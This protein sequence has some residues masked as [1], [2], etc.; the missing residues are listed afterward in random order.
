MLIT[1][2][3]FK[4]LA[5]I[6]IQKIKNNNKK[7]K[8]YHKNY[9]E[10]FIE[11]TKN[12]DFKDILINEKNFDNIFYKFCEY[13][14]DNKRID[15][16]N[17]EKLLIAEKS[18]YCCAMPHCRVYTKKHDTKHIKKSSGFGEAA[19]I[20]S[21]SIKNKVR[22][23]IGIDEN[24]IASEKNGV[25]LCSNCHSY[26]DYSALEFMYDVDLIFAYKNNIEEEVSSY[27]I[28]KNK[29]YN[30]LN[31]S[32]KK[33]LQEKIYLGKRHSGDFNECDSDTAKFIA[34]NNGI[35]RININFNKEDFFKYQNLE[36]LALNINN[37]NFHNV[38][39]L[40]KSIY[41]PKVYIQSYEHR[42]FLLQFKD[43]K[44]KYLNLNIKHCQLIKKNNQSIS[45]GFLFD[46]S[47]N[48]HNFFIFK[49]IFDFIKEQVSI[50]I[51][52]DIENI[53]ESN[54]KIQDFENFQYILNFIEAL[55]NDQV[56][57]KV[58]I[59][60]N[61]GYLTINDYQTLI[62]DL[63]YFKKMVTFLSIVQQISINEDINIDI[64]KDL[65]DKNVFFI[66][67]L[68]F[69]EYVIF[70]EDIPETFFIRGLKIIDKINESQIDFSE[71]LINFNINLICNNFEICIIFNNFRL[72]LFEDSNHQLYK[73]DNSSYYIK[74][75]S[76]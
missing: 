19:H 8:K 59:K 63:N 20:Y 72:F 7:P 71:N 14:F 32:E 54:K 1:E 64:N 18:A 44:N 31:D 47:S 6:A 68:D 56:K 28:T 51:I 58:K 39:R 22:P 21:A 3:D 9:Y 62:C 29:N 33:K 41:S 23:P 46:R 52:I 35:S 40:V 42:D 45:T 25:W 53:I 13:Y 34:I 4:N 43:K 48:L 30:N 55:K 11:Y 66:N 76:L 24:F 60:N 16:N 10:N 69:L 65:I 17:N 38:D 73:T 70:N 2:E 27:L 57:V 26:A 15:F 49:Y 74:I 75:I 36:A 61:E 67:S 12:Y 50:E 5:I 37:F